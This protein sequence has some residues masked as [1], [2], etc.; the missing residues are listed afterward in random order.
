MYSRS[1][2]EKRIGFAWQVER[3]VI[4]DAM[5]PIIF[6]TTPSPCRPAAVQG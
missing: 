1:D 5:R 4:E 6:R 2:P 3:G